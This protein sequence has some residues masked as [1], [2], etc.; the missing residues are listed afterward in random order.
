MCPDKDRKRSFYL[1]TL[2][3]QH[4]YM[5]YNYI[6]RID[7]HRSCES[8]ESRVHLLVPD[9]H[10]SYEYVEQQEQS[11]TQNVHCGYIVIIISS[12]HVSP[13]IMRS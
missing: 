6:K 9:D 11:Q 8:F 3:I 1:I 12:F 7:V 2:D 10:V 13:Y 4:S 5:T